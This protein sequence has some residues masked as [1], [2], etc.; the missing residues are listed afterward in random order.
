V[1]GAGVLLLPGLLWLLEA[2]GVLVVAH[3]F[4]PGRTG[5]SVA[6]FGWL[7][8][9][10]YHR[11]AVIYRLRDTTAPPPA[12]TTALGL[13]VDGRLLLLAVVAWLAPGAV[14]G[15]LVGG[16]IWL[17]VLF[18]GETVATWVEWRRERDRRADR[19]S[20]AVPA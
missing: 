2:A 16:A 14:T 19:R 10:T 20:T 1:L 6:A 7:A 3:V 8:A 4:A 9:V 18:V 13:G 17:A 12:V 15:V 11:Y 5:A